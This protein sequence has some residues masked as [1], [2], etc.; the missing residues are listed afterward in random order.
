VDAEVLATSK[1]QVFVDYTGHLGVEAQ[2]TPPARR[3]L[4]NL[5]RTESPRRDCRTAGRSRDPAGRITGRIVVFGHAK[6]TVK[7]VLTGPPVRRLRVR[8][9]LVVVPLVAFGC[10]L[11]VEG[12]FA[13][14]VDVAITA[15]AGAVLPEAGAATDAADAGAVDDATPGDA[16]DADADSTDAAALCA[17]VCADAGIGTCNPAGTCGIDCT[18]AGACSAAVACPA[19]IPCK[20]SCAGG[21]CTAAID[22]GRATSCTIDCAG[23]GSCTGAIRCSGSSCAIG[24]IGDGSCTAPIS[25]DASTCDVQCPSAD[26][27]TAPIACTGTS[28]NVACTGA[29][30]CMAGVCCDAGACLGTHPACK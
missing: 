2:V 10:G 3:V 29:R 9:L 17:S 8:A 13:P 18:V 6:P 22:C 24:C 14:P 30:T 4:Q 15:E 16:A 19:G 28:C 5:R 21:S 7:H 12:T 1:D 25:C 20:V 23:A 11:A 26:S 27:C